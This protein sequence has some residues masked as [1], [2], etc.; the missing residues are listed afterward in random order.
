MSVQP[1]KPLRLCI[2]EN[3]L[4]PDELRE[5]FGSYPQMIERWIAPALPE[6]SF[7][8]VSPVSGEALPDPREYDGYLLSGSRHSSY[9]NS[10]W[11]QGLVAFLQRLR[12]LRKP[13]FGIC[14]GH[15]I[16]ADAFAGQ[17]TKAEQGWGVGAE[18]YRYGS[19]QLNDAPVF[20]FHQ[21]QV[22]RVP[23]QAHVVGG[24]PHCPNGVLAYEF[25]ALSVQY[26][27]EFSAAY[28]QA[29]LDR[30]GGRMI[31]ADI[32]AEAHESLALPVDSSPVARWAAELFRK[33]ETPSN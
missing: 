12:D 31:P 16:M 2:I 17:T 23:P 5:R 9:E 30:Y 6:A 13:V 11:M 21:D 26:H 19:P 1:D 28:V 7:A 22:T 3:G 18:E 32:S 14:F 33:G 25:P 20:I 15:Q 29:L 4:V 24:S 27:P 8:Y 10:E